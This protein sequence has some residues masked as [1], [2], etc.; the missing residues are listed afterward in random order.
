MK[1]SI[2]MMG[3]ILVFQLLSGC[4]GMEPVGDAD[5][6]LSV[7]HEIPGVTKDR[8]FE[9][10]KIWIA[11][12][13]RSAKKVIEYENKTDGVLIGN[14]SIKMPCSGLECLAKSDWTASFTMRVDMKDDKIRLTYTNLGLSWP[15][16]YSFTTGSQPGYDGPVNTMGDLTAI[17][18]S[19]LDLGNKLAQSIRDGKKPQS[20]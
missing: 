10:S 17:K 2:R 1:H 18:T 12:N 4:A 14:G 6:T 8:I 9:S 11:E 19:L 5:Q 3:Y 15:P 13:F 20:W 16:K 7:V